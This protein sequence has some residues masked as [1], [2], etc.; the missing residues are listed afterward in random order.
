VARRFLDLSAPISQSPPETPEILRTDIE[1]SGHAEGAQQVEALLGVPPRLLRDGEGWAN[2][3]VTRL[4]THNTTHLDAPWHYNSRIRGE[5]AQT[6]DELPLEWFFGD[7]VVLDMTAKEDGE[8]IDVADVESELAGIDH[9]LREGDIVLVRTGRDAHYGDLAYLALGPRVTAGATR[10]MFERGVRV[11]GIDAWGWDGPLHHQAREALERD[12]PGVFWAA[13]QSDLPYA[14][15]ER[16]VNL[17]E[18]P[19]TGFT[20]ACFPLRIVGASGAPARV[21]AI[22]PA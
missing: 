22:L 1:F 14:Q 16:L 6:I 15:I 9:E 10:W 3:T 17:G 5:R 20:V 11:M 8:A 19:P 13:H 12:E 18:L 4:G 21:V 7:G 2:D